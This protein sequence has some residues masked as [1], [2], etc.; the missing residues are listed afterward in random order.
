MQEFVNQKQNTHIGNINKNERWETF[1][2][3][4]VCV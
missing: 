1:K 2:S 4:S 3:G